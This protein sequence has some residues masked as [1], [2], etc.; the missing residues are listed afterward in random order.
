MTST[1]SV[2][3]SGTSG[4]ASTGSST[5]QRVY[6]NSGTDL[7]SFTQT[8]G[9]SYE[10]LDVPADLSFP[11]HVQITNDSATE[12]VSVSVTNSDTYIFASLAPGATLAVPSIPANPYLKATASSSVSVRVVEQ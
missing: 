3:L 6:T 9:T 1:L 7:A 2:S 4:N 11:A 12:T 8:I 5:V 10:Q